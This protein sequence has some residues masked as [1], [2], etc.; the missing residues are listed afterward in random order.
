VSD[1]GPQ[2]NSK[3]AVHSAIEAALTGHL[4][5]DAAL[6][7]AF[8]G[9]LD[10]SV[11]LHALRSQA[12]GRAI[13]AVHIDHGLHPDS[14]SWS[15]TCES[16]CAALGIAF[17]ALRVEVDLDSG[18][19]LEA[20]ARAAR[21]AAFAGELRPGEVLLTAHH[22]R[23]QLETMLLQLFRGAGVHGLAA[24]PVYAARDIRLLRPLLGVSAAAIAAYGEEAGLAWI[25][26]PSNN[27]LGLDRNYLRHEVLPLLTGRWSAVERSVER[28]ARLCA[29]AAELID[30]L[31][32]VD[33]RGMLDGNRLNLAA[34]TRL[35]GPRQR[36]A[37]R[38]ALRRCGLGVP[39]EKQLLGALA[40]LTAARP[41]AQ[42]E[43]AWPGVRIRR[44]RD[45]LWLFSEDLDPG[46][47]P[48]ND[49]VYSWELGSV[50]DLGA[51]RG[52]LVA[53]PATGSGIAAR[54]CRNGLSVRFRRGGEKLRTSRNG[55]TRQLKNLLQESGI[56][57]WMRSHI[58]LIYAGED[59]VAVANIWVN[60]DFAAADN[61]PGFAVAW[62]DHA[63]IR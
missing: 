46:V 29:E 40:V 47:L 57:P 13:R 28:S 11:L 5:A 15:S 45:A 17:K 49:A 50:L 8:S 14:A 61:E 35:T 9:G 36:N 48:A 19:G 42:P 34:L 16:I 18:K 41:D 55:A 54:H 4:A 31:A 20:A 21:Y 43:A 33:L 6:C 56:V 1:L 44:Y 24:M 32:A 63:A 52:K 53:A 12:A 26:D 51:V 2:S 58:P 23:D 38:A 30:E 7:V 39:S 22:Q 60:Q 59:L 25:D 62:R 37:L 27:E 10:S 3:A